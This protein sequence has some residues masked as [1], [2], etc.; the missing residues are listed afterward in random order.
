MSLFVCCNVY[1]SGWGWEDSLED[2]HSHYQRPQ[3]WLLGHVC[4]TT[5]LFCFT[6][7]PKILSFRDTFTPHCCHHLHPAQTLREQTQ[8][9][10]REWSNMSAVGCDPYLFLWVLQAASHRQVTHRC[11][12]RS[13]NTDSLWRNSNAWEWP[14]ATH[15][16]MCSSWCPSSG[17]YLSQLELYKYNNLR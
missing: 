14:G 15:H 6:W 11:V 7:F 16:I 5:W 8:W 3:W 9:E 10:S 17:K 12:V 2:A 1:F 13:L 4:Q